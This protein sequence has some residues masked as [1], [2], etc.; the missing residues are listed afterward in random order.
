MLSHNSDICKVYCFENQF[1]NCLS[2]RINVN[3]SFINFQV[4]F[5]FVK[6][7]Y[8]W[9]FYRWKMLGGKAYQGSSIF[10]FCSKFQAVSDFIKSLYAWNFY[11]MKKLAG[12]SYY[13]LWNYFSS[14]FKNSK[15]P[16]LFRLY[17]T[18][19]FLPSEKRSD[20]LSAQ[21]W[22]QMTSIRLFQGSSSVRWRGIFWVGAT[23]ALL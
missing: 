7:L 1:E 19:T 10:Y 13:S 3:F 14:K 21:I 22:N 8:P 15:A 17:W 2:Y 23:I 11:E 9:N 16:V 6:S 12:R 18:L 4:T 5:V 20:F